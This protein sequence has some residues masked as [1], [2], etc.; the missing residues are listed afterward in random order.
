MS[1]TREP[2]DV[3]KEDEYEERLQADL[4]ELLGVDVDVSLAQVHEHGREVD[5]EFEV[6][7]DP[8]ALADLLREHDADRY[9]DVA[10]GERGRVVQRVES[11]NGDATD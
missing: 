1:G 2:G 6:Q 3:R 4:S 7:P 10:A 9:G 5:L 8:A 11:G